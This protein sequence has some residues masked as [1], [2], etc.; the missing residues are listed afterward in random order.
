[1]AT[2]G[3][4]HFAAPK[5]TGYEYSSFER[6]TVASSSLFGSLADQSGAPSLVYAISAPGKS[7]VSCRTEPIFIQYHLKTIF[8][9]L[10]ANDALPDASVLRME[11]EFIVMDMPLQAVPSESQRQKFARQI[12]ALA[13]AIR[14]ERKVGVIL[15]QT[16][17][18]TSLSRWG[19]QD[20]T[21]SR[22]R[23]L[24]VESGV[25]KSRIATLDLDDEAVPDPAYKEQKLRVKLCYR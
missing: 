18:Q 12:H 10:S 20:V 8:D 19:D 21:L 13:E 24:L 25:D 15:A 4:S 3:C 5:A 9:R 2:S 16:G 22:V 11:D 7:S 17:F 14:D 1:M 6:E 23:S